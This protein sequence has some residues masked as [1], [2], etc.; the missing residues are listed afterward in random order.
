[1]KAI[2]SLLTSVT[3]FSKK[4]GAFLIHTL[5]VLTLKKQFSRVEFITDDLGAS[6]AEEYQWPY[7][8][9]STYFN[10]KDLLEKKNH[11]WSIGKLLSCL[12]TKEPFL[13]IDNDVLLFKRLD[14]NVEALVQSVDYSEL[15]TNH[16]IQK[17]A[18]KL[19]LNTSLDKYNCGI[20]GGTK[21][22]FWNSWAWWALG[23][24]EALKFEPRMGGTLM[25]MTVEQLSLGHYANSVNQKITTLLGGDLEKGAFEAGY[26]HF[27]GESKYNQG[28]LNVA[29]ALFKTSFPNEYEHFVKTWEKI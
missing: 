24:A 2:Q 10:N 19:N 5:S 14:V 23:K 26:V 16:L 4:R 15:Y 28:W 22:E 13:H 17:F 27:I 21:Y 20:M 18:A 9:V 11:I 7:D 29:E 3:P 6:L 25:T 1:M 12:I 8:R